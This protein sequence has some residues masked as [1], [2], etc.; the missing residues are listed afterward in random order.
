MRVDYFQPQI[1]PSRGWRVQWRLSEYPAGAEVIVERASSPTGN[2]NGLWIEV[3]RVDISTVVFEDD[4]ISSTRGIFHEFFYRITVVDALSAVLVS[5]IATD[6]RG[7]ADKYSA[8]VIRQHELR[9]YGVNGHPGY[10]GTSMAIFKRVRLGTACPNCRSANGSKGL[11]S[12]CEVCQGTGYLE[13]YTNP[14]IARFQSLTGD[15]WSRQVSTLGETEDMVNPFWT[16][17]YPAIDPG[18]IMV[19][20]GTTRRWLVLSVELS[21]PNGV[22][23]SQKLSCSLMD[24]QKHASTVLKYPGEP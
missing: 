8:E 24:T 13:G 18:D 21:R 22:V 7:V 11:I 6:A 4:S 23:T 19:E 3:G 5:S 1:W 16:A 2:A 17:A 10:Y 20:K 14:V 15:T 9:L 12:Y